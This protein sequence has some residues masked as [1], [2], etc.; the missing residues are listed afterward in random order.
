MHTSGTHSLVRP[1]WAAHTPNLKKEHMVISMDVVV[2]DVVVVV[3]FFGQ[4][5]CSVFVSKV[6][7]KYLPPSLSMSTSPL[8]LPLP[9]F[10]VISWSLA[11]R[12]PSHDTVLK[13]FICFSK[14]TN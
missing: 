6:F 14:T 5:M 13:S 12:A 7:G 10:A 4:S 8:P 11:M 3:Y 9:V 2:G 1:R